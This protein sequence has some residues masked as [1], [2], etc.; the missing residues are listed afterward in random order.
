[1]KTAV[2]FIKDRKTKRNRKVTSSRRAGKESNRF[3]TTDQYKSLILALAGITLT[4][5][6]TKGELE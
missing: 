3:K 4:K 6:T 1:M 2:A 5:I